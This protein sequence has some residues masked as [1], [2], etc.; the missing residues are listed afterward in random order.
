MKIINKILAFG[1]SHVAGCELSSVHSLEDYLQGK[2]SLEDADNEGKKFSFP[3]ILANQL[4]VPCENYALTGSSNDRSLRKLVEKIESNCLVIF[5]Y[6]SPDRTEFYYPDD[7]L[8]LGRDND[9]FIQAGV[10]W[11]GMI[12]NATRQSSMSHPFN[13]LFVKKILRSHNNIQQ[14]YTCV[15]SI[16][17]A[18]NARVAH[19]S[20]TDITYQY[21]TKLD[22]FNNYLDWCKINGFKQLPYL[23]YDHTAHIALAD[24][25]WKNIGDII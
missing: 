7:G 18:Y 22:G 16:C 11:T 25:L 23:H 10:Q 14:I 6:T 4:N 24:L 1:D 15:N 2:I 3:Q 9:N 12:Q 17:T 13:E 20:M 19:L 8:F 5:G 21:M